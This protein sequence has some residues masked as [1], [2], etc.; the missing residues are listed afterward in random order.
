MDLYENHSEKSLKGD[1][2][3]DTIVNPPLFSLVNT[4]KIL[5]CL[6]PSIRNFVSFLSLYMYC[7]INDEEKNNTRIRT[8]TKQKFF[9][10]KSPGYPA[11]NGD[12]S[13]SFNVQ[14]NS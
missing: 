1:Q 4:F 8:G 11:E 5:S 9:I 6:I 7:T 13:V 2:S 12:T 14:L 10:K 3:N